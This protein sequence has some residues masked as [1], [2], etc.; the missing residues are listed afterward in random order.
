[1]LLQAC[2]KNSVHGGGVQ[3]HAQGGLSRG[4]FRLMPRGSFQAWVGGGEGCLPGGCPGG[5]VTQHVLRQTPFPHQTATA[6]DGTY[7]TAMHSYL[8]MDSQI[9]Q[10]NVH[11]DVE[12]IPK[13]PC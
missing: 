10:C 12:R 7:P 2:V 5:C 6:A 4:V 3:A 11:V 1:M 9:F 13:M 8:K